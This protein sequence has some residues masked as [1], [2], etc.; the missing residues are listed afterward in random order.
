MKLH[1]LQHL[2]LFIRLFGAPKYWD[3]VLPEARHKGVKADVKMTTNRERTFQGEVLR[4]QTSDHVN[5][6]R[7]TQIPDNIDQGKATI[8]KGRK[9]T[10]IMDAARQKDGGG[11]GETSLSWRRSIMTWVQTKTLWRV[12]ATR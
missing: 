5:E 12:H 2:P 8:T 9:T 7:E 4:K 1:L 3:T 11:H 10:I 6:R